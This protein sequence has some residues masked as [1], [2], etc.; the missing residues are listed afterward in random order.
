MN[1]YLA[2]RYDR[3][4]ELLDYALELNNMDHYVTSRWIYII[5]PETI[6]VESNI[7]SLRDIQ[8]IENSDTLICFSENPDSSYGRGVRHVELGIALALKKRV[9]V[10]GPR[11]NIFHTLPGIEHFWSWRDYVAQQTAEQNSEIN[12]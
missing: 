5:T 9:V 12:P 2:A 8:D 1:I 4:D 7:I 11:E 6:E 3:R 10:V